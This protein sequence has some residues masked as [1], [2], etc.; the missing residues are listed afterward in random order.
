[1]LIVNN[2]KQDRQCQVN[3]RQLRG[4]FI[5]LKEVLPTNLAD[6]NNRGLAEIKQK[7]KLYI[8]ELP[9]I[10]I[11]LPKLWVRVRAAC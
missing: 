10:G 2:E 1:M 6:P 7:I 11:P 4:E 8:K 9:H 3:E 5:N